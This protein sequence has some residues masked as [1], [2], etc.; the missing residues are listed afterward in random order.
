MPKR[1]AGEEKVVGTDR[2]TEPFKSCANPT[3]VL[4]VFRG[5]V[6]NLQRTGQK[7]SDSFGVRLSELAL[8]DSVPESKST[9]DE[10]AITSSP[11]LTRA[12]RR[13]TASGRPLINA[14][15]AL[16]SSR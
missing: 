6:H 5:E 7:G 14:M 12:K 11:A 10:V 9:T 15:Q 13:R 8:S 16:V 2:F 4:G 3:R 1:L